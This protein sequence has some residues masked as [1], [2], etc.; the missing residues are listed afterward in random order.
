MKKILFAGALTLLF[1]LA[2]SCQGE[3]VETNKDE[4]ISF[5]IAL[6]KQTASRAT[7]WTN[8]SWPDA[9]TIPVKSF[10]G[11]TS[12]ADFTLTYDISGPSW[13]VSPTINQ[14]G[15]PVTYFAWY[16]TALT[17]TFSGTAS[18]GALAYTVA[19][20]A[21]AQ[22]DLI[23]ATNTTALATVPLNFKHIL[24]QINFSLMGPNNVIV[25]ISN[26]KMNGV[27]SAGSYSFGSNSWDNSQSTPANYDYVTT[28]AATIGDNNVVSLKTTTG[29]GN[30][31]MLIP[32]TF[33]AASTATIT[34]DYTLTGMGGASIDSRSASV[35]LK[36]FTTTTW[37]PSKRYVYL[38]DFTNIISGG[39]ISFTVSVDP[40]VDAAT[41][42][43]ATTVEVAAATKAS[44]EAA[45]AT[46]AAANTATPALTTFPISLPDPASGN[47]LSASISID[48]PETGFDSADQIRIQCYNAT[49]AGYITTSTT[50]WT[51]SVNNSTVVVF[52]KD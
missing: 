50:G 40:W 13:S 8:T 11:T 46:H 35:N 4:S 45:I 2:T 27:M 10:D 39:Q 34:F 31:L 48:L 12:I 28:G 44:I 20:T 26:I 41:T 14:P 6:G 1:L 36:D 42:N 52:T 29:N 16:P 3:R 49:D 33:D 22:E 32:Q 51:P 18:T 15:Y 9:A 43:V 30:S 7:E 38:F 47:N 37:E 24:S 17:P 5:S 19:A 21:A 25:G 23:A